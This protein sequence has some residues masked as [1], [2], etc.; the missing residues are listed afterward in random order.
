MLLDK[1]MKKILNLL[2][3]HKADLTLTNKSDR[4]VLCHACFGS[5]LKIVQILVGA[6]A[7]VNHAAHKDNRTP[8]LNAAYANGNR[9]EIIKFL[10]LNG[11]NVYSTDKTGKTVFDI[12]ADNPGLIKDIKNI[13][14]Q[15]LQTN[16]IDVASPG[17]MTISPPP[18]K[19]AV[20]PMDFS[21]S[22][23]PTEKHN[24][25]DPT[26]GFNSIVTNDALNHVHQALDGFKY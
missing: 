21:L 14:S 9:D 25:T 11:A 1:T 8:L 26:V 5:S 3:S 2:L 17:E 10:V 7:N 20:S 4:S 6:G 19:Y 13:H 15:H 24:E 22:A 12:K 16:K 23:H 18:S